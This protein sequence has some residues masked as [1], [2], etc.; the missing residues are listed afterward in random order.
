MRRAGSVLLAVA[1]LPFTPWAVLALW[2]RLP[3]P[4]WL[5]HGVALAFAA[6]VLLVL[7]RVRSLA[8]RAALVGIAFAVVL[9]WWSSLRPSNQRDWAPDVAR[10]PTARVEGDTLIVENVRNF[11]YRSETDFTERWEERRYDLRKLRGLDLFLSY[12]GSPAIAHTIVSFDFGDGEH[13][14]ISIETR[15]ERDEAYSA[16]RG[17]FRE[18]ELYYVV[19]DERDVVRLR[20]NYRGE[21]VYLYRLRARPEPVRELLLDYVET[22]NELAR[23]P[24]WYNA[25]LENCTTGIRVHTQHVGVAAPW[26]W[27]LL[28]NGHVDEML[29]ERGAIDTSLPFAELKERSN[30]VERARAADHDPAFSARIRAGLPTPEPPPFPAPRNNR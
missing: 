20:T 10:P 7:L 22:M 23:K 21:Q 5:A 14:A 15:K 8:R 29:Y 1:A 27:R 11:D 9:L 2:F 16:I 26:D 12:W 13:L 28:V 24:R 19:A 17:F 4:A 25:L 6:G 30:V 3:G 18:Y